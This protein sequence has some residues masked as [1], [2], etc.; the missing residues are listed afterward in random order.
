MK[1]PIGN[2]VRRMG[3]LFVLVAVVLVFVAGAAGL[4]AQTGAHSSAPTGAEGKVGKN[5][6]VVRSEVPASDFNRARVAASAQTG[7][8]P[9]TPRPIRSAWFALE[10][11]KTAYGETYVVMRNHREYDQQA[12]EKNQAFALA[13]L[14]SGIAPMQPAQNGV[15]RNT[16]KVYMNQQP[17]EYPLIPGAA[18]TLAL[19]RRFGELSG[20]LCHQSLQAV[21]T[22]ASVPEGSRESWWNLHLDNTACPLPALAL[23]TP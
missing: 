14:T 4:K 5:S 8:Q 15:L 6:R 21:A 23:R 18:M 13:T 20:R 12:G 3:R 17:P 2:Q 7:R 9:I 10:K 11:H 19:L 22:R 16:Q 1:L